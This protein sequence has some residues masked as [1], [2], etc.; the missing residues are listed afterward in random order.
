MRLPLA[1]IESTAR[2]VSSQLNCAVDAEQEHRWLGHRVLLIDGSSFSMP[3]EPQLQAH[4][5]QPSG[6]K[7]GCG[8]PV[9]HLLMLFNARTGLAVDA[10]T[11]PLHTH[12]ASL[13]A[14]VHRGLSAGDLVV[15]DDSFGSY[16]LFAVLNQ[17]GAFGLFPLHHK[18][19]ADFTPHRDFASPK[20]PQKNLPRSRW[21]KSLGTDDQ[22]V[23]W[24]KPQEKPKWMNARQ[25]KQVP[26]SLVIR[27][28]RRTVQRP[29]F[30]PITLS[31]ATTLLDPIAY[32]ANE[33][34]ALRIRRWDVETDLR[35]LKTTMGM[36]VLHCKTVDGVKKELWIFLLI[37]NLIRRIM[38]AA[39]KRQQVPVSRISFASAMH[40]LQH[41]EPGQS[42]PVLAVVPHRPNRIEPRVIKRRLKEYD[43]MN[44]PR[45]KLRENLR[46]KIGEI[47]QAQPT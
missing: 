14:D 17:Q 30:R 43:L 46:A 33:L 10:I 4:F 24:L 12:E 21:I 6:Q 47:S 41:A 40:W 16:A 25:W 32:P 5:G 23:E 9:A 18:R 22:L 31:I 38:L 1:V 26:D 35:H 45:S 36:D 37:Y 20:E 8:F 29:G 44:E 15:G 28:I 19:I 34:M 11:A 2:Q 7:P 42:V 13:A 27:E 39:A 3:D